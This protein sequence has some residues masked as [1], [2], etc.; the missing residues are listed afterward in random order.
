MTPSACEFV[1]PLTFS[2]LSG[3]DVIVNV[4]PPDQKNGASVRTWH[5]DMAVWADLMIIAPATVNTIAKIANGFA[6]NAL[7][8]LVLALR[9]PLIAAPAADVDMYENKF[10]RANIKKLE[11]AGIFIV[12]GETGELASGLKGKG[13]LADIFKIIDAAEIVISGIQK[14]LSGKKILITA[15]PTY[16][17]ID[18]V[19]FIGNRSSGKMG[20]ALAKSA[21]LR[22][23]DVSLISG[24]SSESIYPEIN[25]TKV[26]SA[27]D[28]KK[29]V[30]KMITGCDIL[31]MSAAV[32]D[33]RPLH[34]QNKKIKKEEGL[35]KIDLSE[36]D[37]IL[38]SLKKEGK[39]V[40]GFALETDNEIKNAV[41][42]LKKKK[43]DMIIMNSLKEKGSGFEYDTNKINI[44]YRNGSIKKLPLTSKFQAANIILSEIKKLAR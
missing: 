25:F 14:D 13:R 20:Y 10:T 28:M 37:D 42:K 22:G 6:D 21:F 2:S 31:I 1:A 7:T 8:T 41:S 35:K 38:G 15:G 43:L 24:P 26:R 27:A 29:E 30:N 18:P 44:V 23:A 39:F 9:C 34:Q 4:F 12:E 17:D 16:E 40:A 33:Y 11:D 32:S 5:I 36:N 19:R 3:N